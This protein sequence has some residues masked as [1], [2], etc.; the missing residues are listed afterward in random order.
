MT[1]IT[2]PKNL[3]KGEELVILPRK[4]YE[5]FLELKEKRKEQIIEEDVLRWS[6]EAKQLKK[7]GKLSILRSLKD[8]R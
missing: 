3:T 1:T 4:E 7:A 6:K 8:L 2:I 5:E